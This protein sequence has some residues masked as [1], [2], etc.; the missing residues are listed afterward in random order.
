MNAPAAPIFW[1]FFAFF[2]L[3]LC[4]KWS[5]LK[6]QETDGGFLVFAF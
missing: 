4:F 1:A 3:F 6:D 2:S 5:D